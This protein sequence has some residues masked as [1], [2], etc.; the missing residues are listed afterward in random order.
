MNVHTIVRRVL[1]DATKLNYFFDLSS[2]ERR[3]WLI[4]R[5]FKIGQKSAHA[6]SA[7][8]ADPVFSNDRLTRRKGRG[9]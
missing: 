7:S 4:E 6:R 5:A 8:Q 2:D 9:R 3:A 1:R